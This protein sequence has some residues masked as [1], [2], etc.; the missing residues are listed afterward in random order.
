MA[1]EATEQAY[2]GIPELAQLFVYGDSL[3]HWLALVAVPE[4]EVFATWISQLLKKNI[5]AQD[6]EPYYSEPVVVK[7]M[8]RRLQALG[9]AQGLNGIQIVKNLYLTSEVFTAENVL[10]PTFKLRRNVA[11]KH[12]KPQ[13][14]KLYEEGPLDV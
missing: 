10:T 9:R 8:L 1:V 5:R 2:T 13:L 3:S 14:E 4:P 11:Y 12:F 7:E 6:V